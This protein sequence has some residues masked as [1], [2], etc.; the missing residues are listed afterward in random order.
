MH[1]SDIS[2]LTRLVARL[3]GTY[4]DS[5]A[6]DATNAGRMPTHFG[7]LDRALGGGVRRGDLVVL[8]GDVGSG[9]SALALAFA[10]RCTT[11]ALV[12]STEQSAYRIYERALA[13]KARVP[14]TSLRFAMVSEDERVRLATA[15][16][17]LRDQAPVVETLTHGGLDAVERALDASPDAQLVIVD[18][19]DGL[20]VR[21]HAM[22]EAL[23]FAVLA[24]KRLA[25]ARQVVIV[26]TTH[27]PAL[28]RTRRDRRPQLVDFGV[29]GA[30]G[31]HAD[32][33]L[34]LYREELYEA[35]LGVAGAAE[36]SLLKHREGATGYVDLYFDARYVE[37]SDLQ[38]E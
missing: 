3:D 32:V 34:G 35:D 7:S 12:L 16:L 21:D 8:G 18:S 30:I 28:D 19:L 37:F 20:V 5:A 33:V 10:L 6:R 14:M 13:S 17:S 22:D 1:D 24:L 11:R 26:L 38:D 25:L 23:A 29:R 27:L 9:C 36:L 31:L 4:P 15:A 2:P